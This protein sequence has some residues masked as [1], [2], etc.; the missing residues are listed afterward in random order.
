MYIELWFTLLATVGTIV[1]LWAEIRL[2]GK[3]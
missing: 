2:E 3:D 1:G